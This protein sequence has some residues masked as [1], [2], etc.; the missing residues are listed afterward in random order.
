MKASEITKKI[1]VQ[2]ADLAELN[3]ADFDIPTKNTPDVILLSNILLDGFKHVSLSR[4]TA[5]T[6]RYRSINDPERL[7]EEVLSRYI[8]KSA[9]QDF[10]PL[11]KAL[12]EQAKFLYTEQDH[13]NYSLRKLATDPDGKDE[14]TT[15]RLVSHFQDKLAEHKKILD[16]T[17]VLG[18]ALSTIHNM[19]GCVKNLYFDKKD[20]GSSAF[21]NIPQ[22]VEISQRIQ[23]TDEALA[24]MSDREVALRCIKALSEVREDFR[25]PERLVYGTSTLLVYAP[26]VIERLFDPVPNDDQKAIRFLTNEVQDARRTIGKIEGRIARV[27]NPTQDS[28]PEP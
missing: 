16:R 5:S 3:S 23:D 27:M 4:E 22:M 24:G 19:P 1:I 28:S 11:T 15:K 7:L 6:N 14:V 20:I 13:V 9:G 8:I 10:V 18:S 12:F 17:Y 26:A 21:K 2:G 25:K